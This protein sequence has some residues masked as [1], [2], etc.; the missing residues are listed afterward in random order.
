VWLLLLNFHY[1][2]QL[3]TGQI[4]SHST[5]KSQSTRKHPCSMTEDQCKKQLINETESNMDQGI[6][7]LST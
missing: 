4:F 3:Q 1:W 7:I 5:L 2:Q 6:I